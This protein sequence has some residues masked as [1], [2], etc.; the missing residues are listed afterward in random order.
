MI[1]II[2]AYLFKLCTLAFKLLPPAGKVMF[3]HVPVILVWQTPLPPGQTHTPRQTPP[4]RRSLQRTVRILLECILVGIGKKIQLW[5]LDSMGALFLFK[6][7]LRF[8][9]NRLIVAGSSL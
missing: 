8:V 1:S 5:S 3:L 4:Q 2:S 6:D 7:C 9:G